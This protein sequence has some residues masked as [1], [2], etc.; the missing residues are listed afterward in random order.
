MR[1]RGKPDQQWSDADEELL[2]EFVRRISR[3]GDMPRREQEAFLRNPL[4]RGLSAVLGVDL[5][6]LDELHHDANVSHVA[7]L[8]AAAQFTGFGWTPSARGPHRHAYVEA[9]D[10]W[11]QTRD[12][13]AVDACMTRW[14]NDGMAHL[15][16]AVGPVIS[17]AGRHEE[18]RDL[19]LARDR[20]IKKAMSHHEAGEYEA[21]VLILL[22]QTDGLVLD[23][24]EPPFGFFYRGKD[25][26]FEDDQTVAGLPLV[27][28]VVRKA[29]NR[30]VKRTSQSE[31]FERNG[32]IHGRH[33]GFGTQTNSTKAIALL[34]GVIEWLQP[35]A[36]EETERRQTAL[37]A[38]YAGSEQLDAEGR[39]MDKRGFVATRDSLRW[40]AIRE[41][42]E[43]QQ[44]GAYRDDLE[45]MFPPGDVGMI[46][47]A[48]TRRDAI[49]LMVA[50]DRHSW[51]AWANSD[52]G[53]CFGIAGAKGEVTNRYYAGVGP[54]GPPDTDDRWKDDI[55]RPPDWA[56]E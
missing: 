31:A 17:L 8:R 7:W 20:L 21:S 43:H 48:M 32:I 15:R 19:L 55:D 34:G 53:F 49:R 27:L 16:N 18:T 22:A 52:S 5:S 50:Y 14:W 12:P 1:D 56:G 47:G 33:L 6:N 42:N 9:V 37:E 39:R 30:D 38:R 51:W 2:D 3:P 10:V 54:P 24:T 45:E 13:L 29:V 40:L 28:R 23:F 26:N 25:H 41:A 46:A 4:I 35:R 36:R 11:E 44:H